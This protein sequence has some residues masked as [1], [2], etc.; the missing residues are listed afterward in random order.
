MAWFRRN[1]FRLHPSQR[2][3]S[4]PSRSRGHGRPRHPN[5][6][7][8]HFRCLEWHSQII[9][10]LSTRQHHSVDKACHLDRLSMDSQD[11]V[12]NFIFGNDIKV[13][14]RQSLRGQQAVG[15]IIRQKCKFTC[16]FSVEYYG[17]HQHYPKKSV[18]L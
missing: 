14:T 9:Q 10:T 8:L 15:S 6:P 16:H 11:S 13:Y 7:Y 5:L 18:S 3:A 17:F 12:D 2:F 1:K 4:G